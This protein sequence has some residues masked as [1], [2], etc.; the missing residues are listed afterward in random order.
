MLMPC[1]PRA[2][3]TGGAGV[4]EPAG[5]W[6]VR[7][8]RTFLATGREGPFSEFLDLQEV[9]F[10]GGFP[11]EDADE[12]LHLVALGVDLV[13]RA[14]ELGERPVGDPDALALRERDAELRR[15]DAHVPQDLLDLG[16]VERDRLA[17]DARD[18]RPTDEARDARCVP[19]DEPAVGVE[20]HLDEDVA[21]VD[22]L[23]DGVALALADLDLVLH[24][25]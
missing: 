5:S 23:L 25:D 12:D 24:R 21:G 8:V 20:D 3:P 10:D 16:L 14:D 17:A 1:G 9:E 11:A 7:T 4:A 22:L 6:R 19:D 18:V 15:L 2:V 13:D